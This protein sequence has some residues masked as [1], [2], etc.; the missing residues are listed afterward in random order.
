MGSLVC[1]VIIMGAVCMKARQTL[2]SL[3][4]YDNDDK[5]DLLSALSSKGGAQSA[6]Q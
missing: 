4:K 3:H 1:T 2:M 6:L 5:E